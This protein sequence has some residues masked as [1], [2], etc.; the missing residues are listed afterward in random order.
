MRPFLPLVLLFAVIAPVDA[1]Q[2]RGSAPPQATGETA[3]YYFL[4]AQHYENTGRA[5]EA[6]AA[7]QKALELEP[8]SAEI[9]A[10]LAGL[11]AREDKAVEAIDAGIVPDVGGVMT[12]LPYAP[13]PVHRTMNHPPPARWRWGGIILTSI[14]FACL[15]EAWSIPLIFLLSL[16]GWAWSLRTATAADSRT[17]ISR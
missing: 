15:H 17:S 16:L 11:Y 8:R 7:Y 2:G 4:L 9:R 12:S 6:V 14:V 5:S 1:A 10:Q 13:V 3:G